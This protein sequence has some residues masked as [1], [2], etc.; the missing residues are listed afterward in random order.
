[1]DR[2]TMHL[3]SGAS[4]FSGAALLALAVAISFRDRGRWTT[5]IRNLLAWLGF[6]LVLGSATPSPLW[7]DGLLAAVFLAWF[8]GE[9]VARTR[10]IFRPVP[11]RF[12]L[13]GLV[14]AD[15]LLE[16]PHVL[17]PQLPPGKGG[18]LYV[19]GDSISAGIGDRH[20]PWPEVL[21]RRYRVSVTNLARAGSVVSE[22]VEWARQIT[23]P[24]AVVLIEIGGNDLLNG[25]SA[26]DF[27]RHLAALLAAVA[28]PG[29]TIVMLE[30]PLIP[31]YAG[32]GQAQR[33]LAAQYAVFLLPKRYFAA[34][35][36]APGASLDGL[37]LSEAGTQLM[38]STLYPFL[39]P[40]FGR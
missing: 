10:R 23:E 11:L 32:Y 33:H 5:L 31:L 18:R 27:A 29:R 8:L 34:V 17:E 40:A 30:L 20:P 36:S 26:H 24:D 22:A 19:I 35:L 6:A 25:T 14:V 16:I 39:A 15:V 13:I 2:L 4:L 12:A 7:F 28:R 38:A 21:A 37:H 9:E 1:M 3:A